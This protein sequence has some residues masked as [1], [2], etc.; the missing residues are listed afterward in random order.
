MSTESLLLIG[1]FVMVFI[2]SLIEVKLQRRFTQGKRE[3]TEPAFLLLI[4][5]FY[6]AIYLAP[7]EHY[8]LPRNPNWYLIATGYIL[9]ILAVFI[10]VNAMLTLRK[11]F[12]IAIETKQDG[13]L[14][15][16]GIYK[17]IRH[18]LYLATL[19][20][21]ASSCLIFNCLIS[22]L[23]VGL[24]TWGIILRIQKEEQFLMDQFRGYPD[25]CKS[26]RKLVP[27]IY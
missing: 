12:S 3:K 6:L 27:G 4:I 16:S 15:Q 18:P 9:F 23:F 8:V 24:T 2:Y 21:V 10:R 5:P 19:I 14:I 26:S 13:Q 22:W 17:Y 1:Y 25:Y 7:F 20:M 11:N